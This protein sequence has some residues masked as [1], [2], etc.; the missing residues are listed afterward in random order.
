MALS[1]EFINCDVAALEPGVD[2]V[3]R[4]IHC[5]GHRRMFCFDHSYVFERV[6]A[7]KP[8]KGFALSCRAVS[9]Q[10][11]HDLFDGA[12]E[13]RRG[14]FMVP[15]LKPFCNTSLPGCCCH[16]EGL[17]PVVESGSCTELA[18]PALRPKD[19]YRIR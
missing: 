4:E 11:A 14:N 7:Y 6:K 17:C 5:A 15:S 3:R 13:F 8:A 16:R 19:R 9:R 12:S 1:K 2:A 10:I 18:Y